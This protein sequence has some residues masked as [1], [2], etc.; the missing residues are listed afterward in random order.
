MVENRI[1]VCKVDRYVL[2]SSR[3]QI[4]ASCA[5]LIMVMVAYI[6]IRVIS[7]GGLHL[8]EKQYKG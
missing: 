3:R 7:L 5:I 4:E 6:E 1:G 8:R 2:G